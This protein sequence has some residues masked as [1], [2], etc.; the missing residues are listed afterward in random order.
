MAG[1]MAASSAS[2]TPASA[3]PGGTLPASPTSDKKYLDDTQVTELAYT[4][5]NYSEAE[6]RAVLRKLDFVS[7][8]VLAN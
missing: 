6:N 1:I 7:P 8:P 5:G 3:T 2:A 4:A